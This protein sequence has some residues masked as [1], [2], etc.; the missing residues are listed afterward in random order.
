MVL[1]LIAPSFGASGGLYVVIVGIGTYMFPRK[2]KMM[3]N[4]K[5]KVMLQLLECQEKFS[6]S[7]PVYFRRIILTSPDAKIRQKYNS[8]VI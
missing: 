8:T 1:F 2:Y 4:L 6:S 5:G 7:I 3:L